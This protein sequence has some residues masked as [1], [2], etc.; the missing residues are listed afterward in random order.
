[1]KRIYVGP[2]HRFA[3][4]QKGMNTFAVF[5]AEADVLAQPVAEFAT[6]DEARAYIEARIAADPSMREDWDG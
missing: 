4:E 6:A 2:F 5:D 3:Y 1:M